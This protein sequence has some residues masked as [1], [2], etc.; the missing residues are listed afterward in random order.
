MLIRRVF[1]VTTLAL[2]FVMGVGC[3][4]QCKVTASLKLLPGQ[5]EPLT[6]YAA[7]M[8]GKTFETPPDY[9]VNST[10]SLFVSPVDKVLEV[11]GVSSAAVGEKANISVESTDGKSIVLDLDVEIVDKPPLEVA[12]QVPTSMNP[13]SVVIDSGRT[14]VALNTPIVFQAVPIVSST[15]KPDATVM[16]HHGAV[17][18]AGQI[19]SLPQ[20]N[21]AVGNVEFNSPGQ[22]QATVT[23]GQD[24][25]ESSFSTFVFVKAP[26]EPLASATI[27]RVRVETNG[28]PCTGDRDKEMSELGTCTTKLCV[29]A[30]KSRSKWQDSSSLLPASRTLTAYKGADIAT[31]VPKF[32]MPGFP[33]IVAFCGDDSSLSIRVVVG[34]AGLTDELTLA[35]PPPL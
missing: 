7:C 34:E 20:G 23:I 10:A 32:S 16:W 14:I 21:V 35:S 19:Q 8:V 15:L 28:E 17:A 4:E 13:G 29:D 6:K 31:G 5:C 33:E 2:P 30:S 22:A 24:G 25:T 3:P 9:E 26:N 27:R 1:V 18:T 11:C 12:V